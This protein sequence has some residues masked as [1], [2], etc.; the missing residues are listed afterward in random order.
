MPLVGEIQPLSQAVVSLIAAGEVIDSL[1][2]VVRELAENALDA[3]ATRIHIGL[4][5][6]QWRVRVAD[7]GLGMA[8]VNLEQAAAAHSTSK[9]RTRADLSQINSLGFRGEALHS[10]AQLSDLEIV[11]RPQTDA[12][13]WRVRYDATGLPIEIE[14]GAIAPGTVVTADGIFARW[15]SR[16]QVLP[17]IAQQLRT[18][19]LTVQQLALCH[20]Q[21]TWQV[22]Q[23]DRPWFTLW[24]G[25]TAR[26]LLPQIVRGVEVHDL[27]Y[28]TLDSERLDTADSQLALLAGLPDRCHRHRADWVRVAIN[29]RTVNAPVLTQAL[30]QSFRRTLPRHRYPV[31][32]LH[33]TVPPEQVDWNRHPAKSEIYLQDMEG[34]CDRISS[35]VSEALQLDTLSETAQT[36]RVNQL[37]KSAEAPGRYS[38]EEKSA[39]TSIQLPTQLKAIAQ[40]N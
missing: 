32:F 33:L 9:I 16:R 38:S 8:R 1:A 6:Q 27:R 17:S 4:W 19:Q 25:E 24:P 12:A 18:V 26:T 20:P 2:A 5:P 31:C 15:P 39:N 10:L 37:I 40:V 29:G 21:V 22:E 28:L 30:I 23:S 34:W 36:R 13:G 11:S 7:N 14:S 35:A 3:Q